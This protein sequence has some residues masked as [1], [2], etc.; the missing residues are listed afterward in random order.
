MP[1]RISCCAASQWEREVHCGASAPVLL[2][3]PYT[4]TQKD[5]LFQVHVLRNDLSQAEVDAR[6][7]ELW[8]QLFGKPHA[9]LRTTPLPRQYGW[10]LHFDDSGKIGLYP[11]ESKEYEAFVERNSGKVDLLEAMR[12][13]RR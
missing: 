13:K 5:L 3:A 8:Q 11:V 4:Y 12:S 10:G 2:E 7:D 6:R 1:D 9:C